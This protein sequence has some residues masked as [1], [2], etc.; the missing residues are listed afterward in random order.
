M[1]GIQLLPL[2][3]LTTHF[4]F[5]RGGY[6]ALVERTAEGFG[7]IGASGRLTE[8]GL[9]PLVWRDGKPFFVRKDHQE[10]AAAAEVAEL[11]RFAADL[12]AALAP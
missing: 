1:A 5:A 11:R 10:P 9:A 7:G 3:D 8:A 2:V 4:L 6:A 12:T